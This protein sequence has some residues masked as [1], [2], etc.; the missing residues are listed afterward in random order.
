MK[1]EFKKNSAREQTFIS[2]YIINHM[3]EPDARYTR[4]IMKKASDWRL[5]HPLESQNPKGWRRAMFLSGLLATWRATGEEKYL[6]ATINFCKKSCRE[7]SDCDFISNDFFMS[8]GVLIRLALNTDNQD[9][10]VDPSRLGKNTLL[11]LY[12]EKENLFFR[13]RARRDKF[14]CF[15]NGCVMAGICHTFED[16]PENHEERAWYEGLLREMS[17]KITEIQSEDG[18]WRPDLMNSEQHPYPDSGG[19]ALLCYSIAWGI[20]NGI[21]AKEQY[22]P[23]AR[24]AWKGLC[25]CV[26][27]DGGLAYVQP[28]EL[29][30]VIYEPDS[31]DEYATGAFLLAGEEMLKLMEENNEN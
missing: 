25:A 12:D 11:E 3:L 8:P 23:V 6:N 28:L 24:K 4:I 1:P 26:Y 19:S 16:L 27:P 17:A 31:T 7:F 2:R 29:S 30:D 15:A 14:W 5:K 21:L 9:I 10:P 18:L 13:D 20:N 22:E